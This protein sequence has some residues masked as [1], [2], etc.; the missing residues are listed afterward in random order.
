MTS[1]TK[2]ESTLERI[3]RL[4]QQERAALTGEPFNG[5]LRQSLLL[6]YYGARL[7]GGVVPE[8]GKFYSGAYFDR[9][10]D[11]ADPDPNR[12]L[13]EDVLAPSLLSADIPG[14][15]VVKILCTEADKFNELLAAIPYE[16]D[17]VPLDF[18]D[19]TKEDL[20]LAIALEESLRAPRGNGIGPTRA[21]KLVARKR[22]F[23]YPIYDSVVNEQLF[24]GVNKQEDKKFL[25]PLHEI[26]TQGRD[27]TQDRDKGDDFKGALE[28]LR[29][30]AGLPATISPIRILD[31][32]VWMSRERQPNREPQH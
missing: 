16:R 20:E 21:S 14:E 27:L 10:E 28:E 5:K 22:P 29:E 1:D 19:A 30:M 3:Q 6:L 4:I 25:F 7:N 15:M 9:F 2:N 17:G 26:L 13:T 31:V 18:F 24:G 11:E 23:L 32:I 8:G 12:F